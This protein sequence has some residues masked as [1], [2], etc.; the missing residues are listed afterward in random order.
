MNKG[1]KYVVRCDSKV[2]GSKIGL[3]NKTFLPGTYVT[4]DGD[5]T[6]DLDKAYVYT[7]LEHDEEFSFDDTEWNDGLTPGDFFSPVPVR[8]KVEII[9]PPK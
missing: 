9:S 8:L 1:Q 7:H 6:T 5:P 2:K 4:Y 3:G